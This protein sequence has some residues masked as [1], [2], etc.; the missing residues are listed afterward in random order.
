MLYTHLLKPP[1]LY[2]HNC[3]VFSNASDNPYA[4]LRLVLMTDVFMLLCI[5]CCSG[6]VHACPETENPA[7]GHWEHLPHGEWCSTHH[8]VSRIT[9]Y[10]SHDDTSCMHELEGESSCGWEIPLSFI[11]WIFPQTMNY[12]FYFTFPMFGISSLYIPTTPFSSLFYSLLLYSSSMS[13]I[14]QQHKDDDGFLYMAYSG[15][16]SMG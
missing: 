2:P 1:P 16:N 6:T 10:T 9:Y 13:G 8:R 5:S 4:A 7:G 15:E 3:M 12:Y 14:Y 11:H